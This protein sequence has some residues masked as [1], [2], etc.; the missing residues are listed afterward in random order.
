[1]L[2][3]Y[4]KTALRNLLRSKTFSAINI[5]G[6]CIGL[7][8][9]LLIALNIK[10]EHSFNSFNENESRI[11][12]VGLTL[13]AE[14]KVLGNSSEFV[15]ALGP[16][17]LKD[18][19]EVENYVRI[20]TLRTMYFTYGNK[21]FKIEN[22]TYADSSLFSIFSFHLITGNK[23]KALVD[24]YSIM[25]AR[26]TASKIFGEEDPIGKIVSIGN[27]SYLITGVVE[28]PPSNSDIQFNSLISF[29]TLYNRPDV[30]LGWN[31]GNQ[32]ITYVLLKKN[33]SEEQVN[34]RFPSFLWPYINRDYSATGWKVEARL[35]PLHDIHLYYNDDSAGI[36]GNLNTFSAIA[37]FILLIACANFVNLS[38]A[39]A[40]GRMQEVGMRKVLGAQR[41]ILILQFL[42]ESV[43]LCLLAL[44]VALMLV[45]L[46]MPWYNNL[47]GK[48]LLLSKLVD[49]ESIVFLLSI[50]IF[51]GL[52]A[53]LYPALFLSSF[54]PADTLKGSFTRAKQRLLLRRSL[55]ILQFAI[56]TVLIVSTFVINDQL[57]FMRSK[58][59]GFDKENIVV[60]PLVNENLKTKY[61]SFKTE[62]RGIP[63]VLSAAAS[64]DI[65]LNGFTSN[66]YFPQGYN[67]P[68][69][70]H[71]LDGDDDFLNTFGIELIRGRNFNRQ[72]GSDQQAYL[73]NQSLTKL[74][75]WKEPIGKKI[76]RSWMN[77]V[78]GEVRDF[79]YSSLYY[80]IQPLIITDN[81]EIGHFNDISVKLRSNDLPQTMNAIQNVWREFAPMVPFEYRFLDQEF[82][83]VYKADISFREAFM[84]FSWLAIF[85]ALL[86]LL[87]LVS[88]SIELRRK[89]IGIRKVLG[90]S[91]AGIMS[92]LSQ[93]YL[94]WVVAA[95]VVAWPVA[96]FVMRRWLASFAYKVNVDIWAF[97]VSAAIVALVA[98]MTISFQT[99]KAATANPVESL[100]YE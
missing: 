100:R 25:L 11:F 29:S 93:E 23:S 78:I 56:S 27:A 36:R 44:L 90:S 8:A 86:G 79:N 21:S 58:N 53:G 26:N 28:D 52:L 89:E 92:L 64:S 13:K 1:M 18:V 41:K 87:G 5:L 19:P 81:P 67:S 73:I 32:Y 80:P 60:I 68:L 85:V 63:G 84:V 16:A 49:G 39:R 54:R 57:R 88:Y 24:P 66:G 94:K 71:V 4:L 47:I 15:D 99:I 77:T 91:V 75:G 45:E 42:A 76:Y 34:R 70:I 40:T 12:R 3:S 61:E 51:T 62:L 74:L 69:M 37:I 43:L 55:V 9:V 72:I 38:T 98:L 10:F 22:V 2:K 48:H 97:I 31:G 83:D 59:L 30:F 96:Y 20:A 33:A 82:D 14:G 95:N 65:P 7:T 17:M 6:L 50:M 35:Q 46:L